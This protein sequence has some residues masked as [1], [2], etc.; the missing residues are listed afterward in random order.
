MSM[1]KFGQA[2][3][4]GNTDTELNN[5]VNWAHQKME[6]KNG[7]PKVGSVD[8]SLGIQDYAISD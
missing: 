1:A 2:K 4:T 6:E 3:S 5:A 8:S 7:K